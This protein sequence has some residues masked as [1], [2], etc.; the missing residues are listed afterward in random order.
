VIVLAS[1]S[2]RR[3]ELLKCAGI[4]FRAVAPRVEEPMAGVCPR[5]ADLVQRTALRKALSV[6]S[7]YQET[8]LGADTVVVCEGRA[9]GK[10]GNAR[11]A[12]AMLRMLSGRW[13]RVYTGIALVRD[14]MRLVGYERTEVRF[15]ELS[16]KDIARY[17]DSGEPMDKAGAYAIQGEGAALVEAVRGCYS[18]VI[19]L[20]LPKLI[21]M[22]AE[23][24]GGIS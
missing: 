16:N 3:R 22:L 13:H 23:L 12:R 7:R 24:E 8:V 2:P 6:A 11:R 19:G 1:R 14:Q 5:P 20:P 4:D 21:E 15:R 9:L 10:P 18:N 17:V